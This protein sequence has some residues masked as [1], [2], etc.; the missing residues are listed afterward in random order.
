[1]REANVTVLVLD[2]KHKRSSDSMLR[3]WRRRLGMGSRS[4]AGMWISSARLF[5]RM[6]R[7]GWRV[8]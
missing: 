1:M 7:L 6:W 8:V 2:K 3:L 4:R 5:R